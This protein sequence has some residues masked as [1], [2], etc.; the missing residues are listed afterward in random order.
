M[1]WR[2]PAGT[3]SLLNQD[4]E[5]ASHPDDQT[6]SKRK[7]KKERQRRMHLENTSSMTQELLQRRRALQPT[8]NCVQESG[9][10]CGGPRCDERAVVL[11]SFEMSD[12]GC[13]YS[14]CGNVFQNDETRAITKDKTDLFEPRLVE[15]VADE[16]Y[17]AAQDKE[18]IE[19]AAVEERG[20]LV[21]F[22][23][24]RLS[25]NV[26]EEH[27]DGAVHIEDQTCKTRR[28]KKKNQNKQSSKLTCFAWRS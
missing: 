25:H 9:I 2:G 14:G 8:K 11:S 26:D 7:K 13:R 1:R 12:H 4:E 27:R 15:V 19:H 3:T 28:E 17:G 21:L 24:A 20:L 23:L 5:L 18:A 10:Y 22:K 16:A 6:S